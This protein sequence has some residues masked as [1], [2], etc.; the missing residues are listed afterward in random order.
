MKKTQLKILNNA[1]ALFNRKGVSNVRLQDIAQKCGISAGN[2]SYH[3]KTKKDLM[4]GV[5]QLMTDNRSKMSAANMEYVENNDYTKVSTNYI[6]FQV[7][8]RF[9]QRDLLEIIKL[10][11]EAAA[12]F[13]K[14]MNQVISFTKNGIYLAAGKG[15]IIPEPH[16]NHFYYFAKNIWG[17]LNS[18]LIEREVLGEENVSMESILIAIWEFHYPYFTEKG[19]EVYEELRKNLPSM[20][21]EEMAVDN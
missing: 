7:E 1:T 6:R 21:K 14:H 3:Y 2:L 4:E 12:L 9:F 8:H 15:I 18:W 17:I 13:E 20:I 19:L 11:P 16:E 5:L 10:V